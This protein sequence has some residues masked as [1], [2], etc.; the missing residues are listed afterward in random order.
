MSTEAL[1]LQVWILGGTTS[2]LLVA[3]LALLKANMADIKKML[4]DHE[5][6]IRLNESFRERSE[7]RA[8]AAD[9]ISHEIKANISAI[10]VKLGLITNL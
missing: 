6:R 2:L 10:N 3:I 8:K 9:Q 7:E 5:E 4:E 1:Q